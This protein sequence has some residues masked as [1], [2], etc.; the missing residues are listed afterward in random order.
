MTEEPFN[1][2]AVKWDLELYQE[3]GRSETNNIKSVDVVDDYTVRVNLS[4][5]QNSTLEQIGFFIFYMSPNAV[6][7]NGED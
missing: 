5:W 3:K 7:T 6:E 2:D 1:A 4:E